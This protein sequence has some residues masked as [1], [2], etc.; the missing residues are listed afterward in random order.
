VSTTIF[1]NIFL[2]PGSYTSH[3]LLHPQ[4]SA[5]LVEKALGWKSGGLGSS[6]STVLGAGMWIY[7][8]NMALK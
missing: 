1:Y 2:K 3:P 7:S 4:T 6:P 5:Q 8:W